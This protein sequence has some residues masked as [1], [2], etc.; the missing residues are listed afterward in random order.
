MI[1]NE[2]Q[3]P[4]F[5]HFY[6]KTISG[7]IN[8][9]NATA[10]MVYK[11]ANNN[12]PIIGVFHSHFDENS[13]RV[14]TLDEVSD[15]LVNGFE[16]PCIIDSSFSGQDIYLLEENCENTFPLVKAVYDWMTIHNDY[17]IL[18]KAKMK[19]N[20][21]S[22]YYFFTYNIG[23]EASDEIYFE[24][25]SYNFTIKHT[26]DKP[27]VVSYNFG[28]E[29]DIDIMPLFITAKVG[30][31][32]YAAFQFMSNPTSIQMKNDMVRIS[33]Y[34]DTDMCNWTNNNSEVLA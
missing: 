25:S 33:D 21:L 30:N 31:D 13:V 5:V 2:T 18:L 34:I 27:F 32:Y 19:R 24:T 22:E 15:A 26:V 8:C 14:Y 1:Y 7:D 3:N 17:D 11:A 23:I 20:F 16:T 4:L 12:I 9:S 10:D 6:L 28:T 29:S